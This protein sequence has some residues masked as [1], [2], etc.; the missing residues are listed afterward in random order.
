MSSRGVMIQEQ[1]HREVPSGVVSQCNWL[2][3]QAKIRFQDLDKTTAP[4]S[5]MEIVDK[6][7]L[8]DEEEGGGGQDEL[9]PGS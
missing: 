3:H 9:E 5:I 6:K 7:V 8:I 4:P 1:G 2:P